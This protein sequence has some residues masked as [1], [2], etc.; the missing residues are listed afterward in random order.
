M[1]PISNHAKKRP[2]VASVAGRQEGVISR[3][4]LESC[5]LSPEQIKVRIRDGHL[6]PVFH[7]L[8]AV[9]H[10]ALGSRAR[11]RAAALACPG[12]V[13]SHRSGAALLGFGKTAPIVVDLIP[14]VERGRR[15][16]AIKPHRVPFPGRSERGYVAGIPVTSVARTIVDLAGVYGEKDLRESVERAATIRVLDVAAIDGSWR[17]VR[18]GAGLRAFAG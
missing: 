11:M 4:Q 15:I 9:G 16:D 6:L 7:A 14:T 3:R 5:G 18:N 13:I 17:M 1:T 10:G 8:F 12:A 2:T